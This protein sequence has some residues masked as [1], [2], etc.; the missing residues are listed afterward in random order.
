MFKKIK[1]FFLGKAPEAKVE[2]AVPYKVESPVL[3]T[4]VTPAPVVEEVKVEA[5]APAPAPV[6][7]V[8]KV[9]TV[10]LAPIFKATAVVEFVPAGTEA[11]VATPAKKAKAPAKPKAAAIKAPAKKPAAKKPKA[12]AQS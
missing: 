8:A 1:E 7:E 9:E 4:P 3:A 12:P 5:P 11:T 6:V 2:Q 10:T